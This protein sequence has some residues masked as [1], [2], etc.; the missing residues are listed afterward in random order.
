[1][2]RPTMSRS[3]VVKAGSLES[4]NRCTR[5]GCKPCARQIRCTELT[6]M[7]TDLAIAAAVQC[8]ASPGGSFP[9][10]A[11][12]RSITVV[13]N[14]GLSEGRVLSR[15]RPCTPSR[16][17]RS[18]QRHTQVLSLPV[19]RSMPV[20]PTPSAVS[21][22][23]RARQTC[24]CERLRSATTASR[25]ARSAASTVKVIPLRIP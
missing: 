4:L 7:P 1:M 22:M 21:R 25:R 19:R 20:V 13:A 3:L 17:K 8:V 5:W 16:M 15:K 11:M 10:S 14:G 2:Y 23:I 9:V 24:F 6:L 18:C 12:T